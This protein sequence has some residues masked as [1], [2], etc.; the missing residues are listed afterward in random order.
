MVRNPH[1]SAFVSEFDEQM[2]TDTQ[3]D[4]PNH[5]TDLG[6]IARSFAPLFA[7]RDHGN[8]TVCHTP[9]ANTATSGFITEKEHLG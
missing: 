9:V 4:W 8:K 1:S 6:V 3:C 7:A 2:L 5:S